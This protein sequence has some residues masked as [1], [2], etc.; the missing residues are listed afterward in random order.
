MKDFSK[1]MLSFIVG[2]LAGAAAGL[3]LAPDKGE[4]TRKKIKDSID[5][6][7]EKAKKTFHKEKTVK[8]T[9]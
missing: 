2:A 8:G 4:N 7:S 6:L 3:L 5:D 9:E 1:V